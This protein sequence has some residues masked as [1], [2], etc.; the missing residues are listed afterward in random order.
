MTLHRSVATGST[1]KKPPCKRVHHRPANLL[2]LPFLQPSR[3]ALGRPAELT[4]A[5]GPAVSTSCELIFL[6]NLAL[7]TCNLPGVMFMVRHGACFQISFNNETR[8]KHEKCDGTR[9]GG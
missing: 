3:R 9:Y 8:Y 7:V 1:G 5:A 6:N 4:V 2:Y